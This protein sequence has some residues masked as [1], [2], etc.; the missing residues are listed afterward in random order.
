MYRV[1][2]RSPRASRVRDEREECSPALRRGEQRLHHVHSPAHLR[3]DAR[4]SQRLPAGDE[5]RAATG[6]EAT[7]LRHR[8]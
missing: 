8:A 3:S 6:P 2:S 7:R 1:R 4:L 5:I